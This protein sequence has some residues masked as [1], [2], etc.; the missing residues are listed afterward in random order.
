MAAALSTDWVSSA[1]GA[2]AGATD[3][4]AGGGTGGAVDGAIKERHA[5]TR[6]VLRLLGKA[7]DSLDDHSPDCDFRAAYGTMG[8]TRVGA[9]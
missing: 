6:K 9:P 8:T 2:V 4:A 5:S 3:G 7:A 1:A